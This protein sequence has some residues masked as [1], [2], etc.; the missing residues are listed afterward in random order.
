MALSQ[1]NARSALYTTDQK[2]ALVYVTLVDVATI[3]QTVNITAAGYYYFDGAVWVKITDSNNP[4]WLV[5]GNYSGRQHT[6]GT[7]DANDLPVITNNTEKMRVTAGG[8]VGINTNNP[9]SKLHIVGDTATVKGQAFRLVDGNQNAGYVLTCDSAGTATWEASGVSMIL[10]YVPPLITQRIK[11]PNR[12]LTGYVA[13]P[14]YID[15]PPG[16][17]KTEVCMY[18]ANQAS[19]INSQINV[20]VQGSFASDISLA[21]LAA[22]TAQYELG[23]SDSSDTYKSI[24]CWNLN[25]LVSSILQGTVIIRNT[26][27][28]TKRYYFVVANVDGNIPAP[29]DATFYETGAYN[30]TNYIIATPIMSFH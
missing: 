27:T 16:L 18:L 23:L 24:N 28:S 10:G 12:L 17:W 29:S 4:A 7:K 30:S 14:S 19:A 5:G 15:L 22:Y 13:T 20:R 21:A 9:T 2:G 6:L 8:N 11:M 26:T 1:L 25:N 3:P